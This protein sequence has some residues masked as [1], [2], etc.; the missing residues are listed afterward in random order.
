MQH[1]TQL[2]HELGVGDRSGR[3]GHVRAAEILP[4]D[5]FLEN[6]PGVGHVKP[7]HV[8]ASAAGRAAE[9]PACQAGQRRQRPAVAAQHDP[10]SQH[11]AADA[12]RRLLVKGSLPFQARFGE[13][14]GAGGRRFVADPV[15]RVAVDPGRAGLNPG[16]GRLAA[17][18]NRLGQRPDR[19]DPAAD[20]FAPIRG[21]VA[22]TDASAGQVHDGRGAVEHFGPVARG[23][24]VPKNGRS[25]NVQR[26]RPPGQDE[27]LV[28]GGQE[29]AGH[30]PAQEAAAAGKNDARRGHGRALRAL[31]SRL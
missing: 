25:Q 23:R 12:R 16:P 11:D 20:D 27:N 22:A 4:P 9:E 31:E 2:T 1:G 29:R 21:R 26:R 30:G 18:A 6:T 14:S 13:E 8:L 5:R 7:T 28:P 10:Q 24:G 3:R 15:A 19:F 17:T